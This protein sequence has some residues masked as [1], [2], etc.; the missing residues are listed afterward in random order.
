MGGVGTAGFD[1]M[2]SYILTENSFITHYCNGERMYWADYIMSSYSNGN[3]SRRKIVF[4]LPINGYQDQLVNTYDTVN[5][6]KTPLFYSFTTDKNGWEHFGGYTRSD[7]RVGFNFGKESIYKGIFIDYWFGEPS[8]V[9]FKPSIQKGGFIIFYFEKDMDLYKVF[10]EYLIKYDVEFTIENDS[11][12]N[13][14]NI[15]DSFIQNSGYS[16]TNEYIKITNG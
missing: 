2:K 5:K 11:V 14:I 10:K 12:L 7:S 16:F 6:S 1:A 9:N 13:H 3:P 15:E 8:I 4:N